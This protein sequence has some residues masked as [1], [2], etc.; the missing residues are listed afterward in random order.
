MGIS[1][2]A[3]WICSDVHAHTRT[4]THAHA[5][6]P[7]RVLPCTHLA[8]H[9]LPH[10]LS[11]LLPRALVLA[12]GDFYTLPCTPLPRTRTDGTNILPSAL[13]QS[14]ACV[15]GPC[16]ARV[17]QSKWLSATPRHCLHLKSLP[18]L[19][20]LGVGGTFVCICVLWGTFLEAGGLKGHRT[21]LC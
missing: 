21:L 9:T 16:T 5:L 8:S 15:R 12:L 7:A 6:L 2:R 10:T 18:Q 17:A 14:H 13:F 11:H 19:H 1:M 20:S 4:H 3:L